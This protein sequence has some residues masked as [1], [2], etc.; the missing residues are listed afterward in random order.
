VAVLR[1][2]ERRSG[3]SNR[4]LSEHLERARGLSGRDRGLVTHLVYGVLRHRARLDGHIDAHA[5]R[6]SKLKGELRMVLRVAALELLELDHPPHAAISESVRAARSIDPRG[7]MRGLLHAIGSRIAEH[8]PARDQALEAGPARA[9]LIERW[10]IP[11]WIADRWL[12]QLGENAAL[13]RAR[14]LAEPPPIDVRIVDDA[15]PQADAAARLAADHSR[16]TIQAPPQFPRAL[17]VSGAGDLFHG[18]MFDD[19]TL[20]VQ[21]LASQQVAPMLEVE[22]G[23]RVLDACAGIGGKTRQLAEAIGDGELVAADMDERRLETLGDQ[24]HR[25]H[26]DVALQVVHGDLREH[27]DVLDEAPFDAILVDAP[28]TGLGNLAR[29]PEIRWF[30]EPSD[31]AERIEL[32]R[33]LLHRCL[34]RVRPGGRL[35]Y[36]VCSPEPDEGALLVQ[37]VLEQRRETAQTVPAL[38][39][40]RSLTPEGDGTEGFYA[41]R[42]ELPAD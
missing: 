1:D 3:F 30:R 29:H 18:P 34:D 19:G 39:V 11:A 7:R 26:P 17:R 10:S 37:T 22:P 28:C 14:R 5:D 16:A 8:G 32:Q 27:N 23:M 36:A 42:L 12:A 13:E 41:A 33:G 9:A 24:L 2:V 25:H 38:T 15:V 6:P 31:L 40:E 20:V 4:V 35:V 21:G